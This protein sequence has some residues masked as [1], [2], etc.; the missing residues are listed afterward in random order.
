MNIMMVTI[1]LVVLLSGLLGLLFWKKII[2]REFLYIIHK[3]QRV[4][5]LGGIMKNEEKRKAFSKAYLN[6]SLALMELD[7]YPWNP[8]PIPTPYVGYAPRPSSDSR[9]A[10]NSFQFRSKRDVAIPKP[11]QTI[12]LFLVG[13]ST[14]FG[15]G[16]PDSDRTIGGY[17]ESFLQDK[18]QESGCTLEVFTFADAAW[19]STHERIAIECRISE[20]EP[21]IVIVLSGYNEAHWAWNKKDVL[22]FRTYSDSFY[23]DV[24]RR[25]F[26]A[27]GADFP[28]DFLN[29]EESVPG[30]R[31]V[32]HSLIKNIRLAALSLPPTASY[33][34]VL[35]PFILESGKKLSSRESKN[36]DRWH[37]L[38]KK[39]YSD[40]Y[41]Y[42]REAINNESQSNHSVFLDLSNVFALCNED[43]EIFLDEVHFGDRGNRYIAQEIEKKL[44][45]VVHQKI[46]QLH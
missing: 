46:S 32:A 36:L 43:E 26:G 16:A 34:F 23:Y 14:A 21:D 20:L 27:I 9:L 19:T 8:L 42:F 11:K 12:R 44:A 7:N 38:Q 39:Y 28:V 24:L 1:V 25:T 2:Y 17:L 30:V 18:Y 3:Q 22:W 5:L 41:A 33:V 15:S 10:I 13:N 37:P 35:Q 40:C 31:K 6:P 29:N 45:S 4:G